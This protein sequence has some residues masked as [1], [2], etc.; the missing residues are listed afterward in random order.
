MSGDWATAEELIGRALEIEPSRGATYV[1]YGRGLRQLGLTDEAIRIFAEATEVDPQYRYA[2]NPLAYLYSHT[3]NFDKAIEVAN[4]YVELAPSEVDAHDTRGDIYAHNGKPDQ[5][6]ENYRKALE[7]DPNF[8]I[9]WWKLT[10]MY[11][12]KRDY[13]RAESLIHTRASSKD[14]KTR[15]SASRGLAEMLMFQG[16]FEKALAVLDQSIAADGSEQSDVGETIHKHAAKFFIYLD[17]ENLDLALN[18]IE[19]IREMLEKLETQD[20][21]KLRDMYAIGWA[22]GGKISEADEVLRAWR[23]DIH[24]HDPAQMS[25]YHRTMGIVELIKGNPTTAITYLKMGLVENSKPLF[26]VRFFLGQAYVESGQAKEAVEIL[27]RALLSHDER[28]LEVPIFSVKA[29]YL[30]GLAYQE[31]GRSKEAIGQYREFLEIWKH[32]DPGIP[33]VEDAKERL[34]RLRVES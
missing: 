29:H 7:M 2:Y 33:E 25:R 15:S 16:K 28:R 19:T 3:G 34:K 32:A 9:S 27:E 11:L 14:K 4:K 22:V 20:P 18:E 12:F 13:A 1:V 24:E 31:L 8:G 5:A 26:E 30:L 21:A 17:K 6:I 10:G 23:E